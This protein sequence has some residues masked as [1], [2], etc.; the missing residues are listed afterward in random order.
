[1]SDNVTRIARNIAVMP[2]YHGTLT[3]KEVDEFCDRFSTQ[4]FCNGHLRQIV[5]TPITANTF[6]FHTE[7]LP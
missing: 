3:A 5:F 2:G 4:H 1:M 6:K 7:Q